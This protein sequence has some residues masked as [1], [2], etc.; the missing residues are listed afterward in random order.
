MSLNLPIT[1]SR[2][3]D[4]AIALKKAL[5]EYR[6]VIKSGVDADVYKIADRVCKKLIDTVDLYY[7]PDIVKAIA[8]MKAVVSYVLEY[9]ANSKISVNALY[10]LGI[11]GVK[12]ANEPYYR[13]RKSDNSDNFSADEMKHLPF[14]MRGKTK[15]SRFGIAGCPSIN[16]CKSSFCAWLETDRPKY[17]EFNVSSVEIDNS[18]SVLNLTFTNIDLIK[19]AIRSKNNNYLREAVVIYPLILATSFR[20]SE[21][22]RNFKSEYIISQTLMQVLPTFNI[23]GVAYATKKMPDD[24]EAFPANL[25]LTIL[26]KCGKKFYDAFINNFEFSNSINFAE[27]LQLPNS[28]KNSNSGSDSNIHSRVILGNTGLNYFDTDFWRY[29]KYLQ[30]HSK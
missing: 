5:N 20:I 9:T 11:N 30:K 1:L 26:P 28:F 18:I 10:K 12:L 22:N 7:K 25:C 4:Y 19:S 15:N 24:K 23:D 14:N 27:F 13:A 6:Q 21:E 29:D 17:N 16:L 3:C 8:N 2:D